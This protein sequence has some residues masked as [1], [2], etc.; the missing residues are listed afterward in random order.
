MRGPFAR[1]HPLFLAGTWFVVSGDERGLS[2]EILPWTAAF[3]PKSPLGLSRRPEGPGCSAAHVLISSVHSRDHLLAI[4]AEAGWHAQDV[5]TGM[6]RIVK[7]WID[8]VVLVEVLAAGEAGRY[9]ESF[10]TA[11]L[12]SLDARLRCLE[13]ES[14]EALSRNFSPSVIAE[15]FASSCG[16]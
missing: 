6:F 3:D 5:E 13:T 16:E 2:L 8:E 14:S 9:V 11:G 10:G 4:A 15:A 7:L 12:P 1:L